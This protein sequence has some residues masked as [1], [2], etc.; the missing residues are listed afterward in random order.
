MGSRGRERRA[1]NS[2]FMERRLAAMGGGS[3][4]EM[5]LVLV[6]LF[7]SPSR[8]RSGFHVVDLLPHC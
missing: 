8:Y 5:G 1:R 3:G 6:W 2:G 4:S 7:P